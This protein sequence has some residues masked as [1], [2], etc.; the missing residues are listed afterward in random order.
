MARNRFSN[1]ELNDGSALGNAPADGVP[2]HRPAAPPANVIHDAQHCL[3]EAVKAEW[4]DDLDAA[5]RQYATALSENPL[6]VEAWIGQLW[7]LSELGEFPELD[8][9]SK[10]A[11]THFPGDPGVLSLRAMAMLHLQLHPEARGFS[12]AALSAQQGDN[13]WVWLARAELMLRGKRQLAEE[14]LVHVARCAEDPPLASLRMG[15]VCLRNHHYA[16]ALDHLSLA[17]REERQRPRP[18]YLLA[19]AQYHAGYLEAAR[20]SMQEAYQLNQHN[21][22][23]L[24]G[25]SQFRGSVAG[26][27]KA[28]FRRMIRP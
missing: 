7:I 1:L 11:L 26:M 21:P 20:Q 24:D 2:E 27:V 4:S 22:R 8:L 13:E 12:D 18:W 17:T 23:Y 19:M 28:C 10:K 5:L 3:D 6:L 16:A 25:L 9:W 15:S 14:C